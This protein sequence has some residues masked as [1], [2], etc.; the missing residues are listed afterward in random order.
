MTN[1]QVRMI[2]VA[3]TFANELDQTCFLKKPKFRQCGCC[4]NRLC[5]HKFFG[6]TEAL[7]KEWNKNWRAMPSNK[8]SDPNDTIEKRPT[9]IFVFFVVEKRNDVR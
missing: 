2:Q 4:S 1:P 8:C 7:L 5:N 9:Q 6:I 3:D